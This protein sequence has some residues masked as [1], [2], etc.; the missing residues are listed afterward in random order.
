MATLPRIQYTPLT[1]CCSNFTR[2]NTLSH[3]SICIHVRIPAYTQH[4]TQ[5]HTTLHTQKHI[6]TLHTHTCTHDIHFVD[7]FLYG[8]CYYFNS[9][10]L[11]RIPK[12]CFKMYSLDK[13]SLWCVCLP[14]HSVRC[15]DT[16]QRRFS[17]CSAVHTY[18]R[19]IVNAIFL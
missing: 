2:L 12:T 13:K 10:A 7:A 18:S 17:A 8:T 6:T 11:P 5:K 19:R 15:S 4:Y 16:E 3:T 14:Y 1:H 9:L